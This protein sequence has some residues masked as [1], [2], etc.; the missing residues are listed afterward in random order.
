MNENKYSVAGY[1]F[2]DIF[3]YNEAK[4]EIESVDYI[5]ANTD[6]NDINKVIKLYHKLVERKTFRTVIGFAFLNELRDKIIRSGIISM[7][8]LPDIQVDKA[9][10]LVK[11]YDKTVL[12]GQEEKHQ[13]ILTD[14]KIKLRNSRIISAFLAFIIMV[15]IVISVFSDRSMY[16]IYENKVID[17]YEAWQAEL[18]AR[19]EALQQKGNNVQLP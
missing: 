1:H 9:E 5:K 3:D 10:R 4:R 11:N 13:S 8:I 18:E 12:A 15:M 6:L 19:E 7:D 17:K 16:S 14:Y 2:M